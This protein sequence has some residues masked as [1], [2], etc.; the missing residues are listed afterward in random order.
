MCYVD[1]PDLEQSDVAKEKDRGNPRAHPFTLAA[2][3]GMCWTPRQKESLDVFSN[4][5]CTS[6][7]YVID[8]VHSACMRVSR[9]TL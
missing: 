2:T 7:R 9:I 3:H 4:T 5:R 6:I 1:C 8:N